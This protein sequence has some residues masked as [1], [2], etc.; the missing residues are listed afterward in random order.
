ME[1]FKLL[2]NVSTKEEV[3]QITSNEG[4]ILELLKKA[5]DKNTDPSLKKVLLDE[6]TSKSVEHT[7]KKVALNNGNPME[8]YEVLEDLRSSLASMYELKWRKGIFSEFKKE[9]NELVNQAT[10]NL[11]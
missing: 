1:Q 2:L 7:K 8:K 4:L 3:L 6:A 5:L 9:F 10:I 11:S